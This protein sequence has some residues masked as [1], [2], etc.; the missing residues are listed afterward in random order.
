MTPKNKILDYLKKYK[1]ATGNELCALLGISRQALN[2]HLK[3]LINNSQILKIGG[4]RSAKYAFLYP[5]KKNIEKK[6]IYKKELSL[7]GLEEDKVLNELSLH[8]NLKRII[9]N[10][11]YAIFQYAFTE[12]LNNAIDHSNSKKCT[13]EVLL[14]Q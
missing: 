10:K 12:I 4:T 5:S 2:K 6:I 3:E 1:T 9:S 13:I 14:D 7:K 11:S 8:A